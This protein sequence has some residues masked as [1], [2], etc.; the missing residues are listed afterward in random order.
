LISGRTLENC[1]EWKELARLDSTA[2]TLECRTTADA[3]RLLDAGETS[4][5]L[6]PVAESPPPQDSGD[7]VG[8]IF[9][10]VVGV[11]VVLV[12]VGVLVFFL[13]IKKKDDGSGSGD[14]KDEAAP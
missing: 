3:R 11:V 4:L 12:V 13:V 1:E 5:V 2:F 9:G 7:D 6:E 14:K 10:V 8:V